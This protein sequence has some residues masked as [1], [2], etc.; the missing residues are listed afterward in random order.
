VRFDLESLSFS[1]E[2]VAPFRLDLTVWVLRRRTENLI[3]RWDGNTYRRVFAVQKVPVEV[4]VVQTGTLEIPRLHI[5]ATG[6]KIPLGTQSFLAST[7]AGML[8]TNRDLAD[9]YGFVEHQPKLKALVRQFRGVKPPRFPT[10]FEALVNAV[11]CQ[12]ISL[13]VGILVLNR[14]ASAF[15]P[16]VSNHEEHYHAFPLPENLSALEPE[17]L[18]PLGLSR[19]KARAI[20]EL[21]KSITGKQFNPAELVN[22]DNEAAVDRLGK[23]RGVGRWS[24]EYVLLRALGR[25]DVFP[26]DDV[27]ARNRL[28]AWLDLPGVL[29]YELVNRSLAP[30]KAYGGLVYFHLLLKGLYEAGYLQ[31]PE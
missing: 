19:Q 30:W 22:L 20:I 12:Q 27:G 8:G 26:A 3:D 10:L 1:F 31:I 5:Q 18:R 28:R 4:E 2:P 16:S 17:A 7:L 14:L 6:I 21:A 29:N 15:G 25:L 24:A 23:L 13:H 11:A 9:F